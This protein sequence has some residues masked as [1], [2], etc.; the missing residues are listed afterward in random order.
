MN[1]TA[2]LEALTVKQKLIKK[3]LDRAGDADKCARMNRKDEKTFGLRSALGKAAN[4]SANYWEG[5][6]TSFEIAARLVSD[7]LPD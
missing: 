7:D 4:L 1:N 2:T 5:R 6:R 3:F